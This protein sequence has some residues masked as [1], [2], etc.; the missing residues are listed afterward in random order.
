MIPQ[1]PGPVVRT[2][3]KATHSGDTQACFVQHPQPPSSEG[4]SSPP[5]TGA[6]FTPAGRPWWAPLPL[7][8]R[9]QGPSRPG[10]GGR[11]VWGCLCPRPTRALPLLAC[12]A[13]TAAGAARKPHSARDQPEGAQRAGQ[14]GFWG[15][16]SREITPRNE[17]GLPTAPLCPPRSRATAP[18]R[19]RKPTRSRG[20]ETRG[21]GKYGWFLRHVL[22]ARG[23]GLGPE[24]EGD[25]RGCLS[26]AVARPAQPPCD[27]G[28]GRSP[29]SRPS[30]GEEEGHL[31]GHL[32]AV[33]AQDPGSIPK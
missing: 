29:P 23:P 4:L 14:P 30:T 8:H 5:P 3:D 20:G 7:P 22:E 6:L 15:P 26:P 19:H 12:P 25:W 13:R 27:P 9:L 16:V 24:Q 11:E 21:E 1:G 17:H 2:R 33:T 18:R 32:C 31:P 10:P 28:L